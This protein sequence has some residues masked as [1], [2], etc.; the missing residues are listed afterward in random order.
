MNGKQLTVTWHVDNLKVSHEDKK[1]VDAFENWL[2]ANYEDHTPMKPSRGKVH[3]YLAMEMDYSQPGKLK[4]NMTK[5]IEGVIENFKYNDEIQAKKAATPAADHLLKVNDNAKKLDYKIA[6]EF[7]TTVA[8][9]LFVCKRA[10]VDI[11]TTIAFLC[12]RVKAPDED[13]WKKLLRLMAYIR[14]T[15][16]LVTVYK[17][18]KLDHVIWYTDAAYGVHEDRKSHTGG[19]MMIGKG[20]LQTMSLK[21]KINTKSSTEAEL[22][23]NNV[24]HYLPR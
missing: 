7:H 23:L 24:V 19:L 20:A 21:Q 11:Q 22:V 8:K 4:I 17:P 18:D 13:D 9:C 16:D 6:E 3:D 2:R 1:I 14:D 5:Y 15:K 10:R 12:T